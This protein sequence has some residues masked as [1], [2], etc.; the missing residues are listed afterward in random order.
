MA[1]V[2]V[3]IPDEL[4]ATIDA[5]AARRSVSRD[6]VVVE[7]VRLQLTR[8]DSSAAS[9]DGEQPDNP[10]VPPTGLPPDTLV[11]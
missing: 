8:P 10:V 6:A 4:L 2:M 7:A 3:P 5:E 1:E 9:N 11:W